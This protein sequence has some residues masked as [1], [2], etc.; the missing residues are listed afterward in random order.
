MN[1]LLLYSFLF[2]RF[3]CILE[4]YMR[5]FGVLCIIILLFLIF[6]MRLSDSVSLSVYMKNILKICFHIF[7]KCSEVWTMSVRIGLLVVNKCVY[8]LVFSAVNI[9][10]ISAVIITG[11]VGGN[12]YWYFRREILLVFSAVIITGKVGG[13][14]YW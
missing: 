11:M 14:Y 6:L 2:C 12:Y 7:G 4:M 1:G 8:I 10:G 5:I 3:L 9:I 13:N